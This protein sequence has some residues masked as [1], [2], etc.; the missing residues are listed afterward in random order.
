VSDEYQNEIKKILEFDAS[1]IVSIRLPDLK[2]EID[3]DFIEKIFNLVIL[4]IMSSNLI[5]EKE[6]LQFIEN[7]KEQTFQFISTGQYGQVL[8]I[9]NYL[10]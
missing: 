5:S 8:Q 3:D 10:G 2:K 6:Y 1:G 7:L 9:I 4:E